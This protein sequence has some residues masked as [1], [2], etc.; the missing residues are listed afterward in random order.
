MTRV[1][2]AYR[3]RLQL[4]ELR[5]RILQLGLRPEERS[6]PY[7]DPAS[8]RFVSGPGGAKGLTGSSGSGN[9]KSSERLD[10]IAIEKSLGAKAK[11][12]DV[13]DLSTGELFHFAEGTH[14]RDVTVFAG[15]G[16][17]T[18]FRKADKYASRYGGDPA[19]WQHV[20]GKGVLDTPDGDR[21]A[22]VHWVQCSGIG[23]FEFFIKEWLE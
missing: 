21:A 1:N 6:N 18:A 2:E 9:I 3:I 13:M 8:G 19:D 12:Y 4:L 10:D 7:H 22:E 16:S 5:G 11:N 23:K 20:K 14:I 17:R 15:K